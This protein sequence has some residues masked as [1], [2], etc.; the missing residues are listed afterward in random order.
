MHLYV[1]V[2]GGEVIINVCGEVN[3]IKNADIIIVGGTSEDLT[4]NYSG[5]KTVVLGKDG[6]YQGNI[7]APNAAVELG[8]NAG[9]LGSIC[10]K[11]I[12]IN[13][14]ARVRFHGLC[15]VS[16]PVGDDE[17]EDQEEVTSP[18]DAGQPITS[19]ELSQNYPNPFNPTT[20]IG[21]SLPEASD[22]TLSI[23][24]TNGQLVKRLVA[25][26]MN[27]GRHNFTWDATDQNGARVASGVYLYVLKA[28]EFVAQR[29]LVLMK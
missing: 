26:A 12:S 24:N 29:K 16:K 23:Y 15:A 9:F 3:F 13:K 25:G 10:A 22:V 11:I 14:D 27:A 6:G 8:S 17:E 4:I 2:S 19:Y 1:D 5:T 20:T 28:G 18:A 21:F 7:I